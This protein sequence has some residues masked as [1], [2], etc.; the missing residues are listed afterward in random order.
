V[1]VA[2]GEGTAFIAQVDALLADPAAAD[3]LGARGRAY[4]EQNFDIE[5]I[6]RRFKA[7]AQGAAN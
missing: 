3:R 1:V 6:A 5:K 4:A 2:P 7:I